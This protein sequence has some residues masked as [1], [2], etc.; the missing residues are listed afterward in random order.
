MTKTQKILSLFTMLA[1]LSLALVTPALAFEGRDGDKVVIAADEVIDDDL[2]VGANEFILDGTVT[3][4]LIVGGTIITINGTVEGDLWAAG[5]V[6]IV[7]GTVKDDARIAGAGLRTVAL[8]SARRPAHAAPRTDDYF[9]MTA[10][11]SASLR[12]TYWVPSISTL[13]PL[14]LP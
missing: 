2:Y 13:V 11:T 1:L 7:N 10:R 8:R 3:G 14:Y 12:I 6:I 4:D 9:V 5:Q